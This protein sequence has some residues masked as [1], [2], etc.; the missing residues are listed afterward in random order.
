[1]SCA[2]SERRE[3]GGLLSAGETRPASTPSLIYCPRFLRDLAKCFVFVFVFR[4]RNEEPPLLGGSV[5][6][7]DFSNSPL[8]PTRQA[9]RVLL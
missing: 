5:N 2:V 8:G 4:E 1:M 9:P 3:W 7:E 6:E